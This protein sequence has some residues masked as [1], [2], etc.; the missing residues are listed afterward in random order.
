MAV[1]LCLTLA[2]AS[3]VHVVVERPFIRL[4]H[5]LASRLQR[6]RAERVSG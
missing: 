4:G 6:G 3:L 2:V 1:A 5:R